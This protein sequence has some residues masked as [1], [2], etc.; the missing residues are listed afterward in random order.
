MKPTSRRAAF[1]IAVMAALLTLGSA[2]HAEPT[3]CARTINKEYARYARTLS[4]E[5]EKCKRSVFTRGE[6]ST[7]AACPDAAASDKIARA[8]QKLGAKIA[9]KCGG[10]NKICSD[11]D[12]G[13]DADDPL[14]AINWDI[15]TCMNF[16]AG[17]NGNC[18]NTIRHC[19]DVATCL[20]C[21]A[22]AAVEQEVDS[23]IYDRFDPTNFFLSSGNV[24][25]VQRR[26]SQTVAQEAVKFIQKKHKL[27]QKC[28]DKKLSGKS[29]FADGDPCPDTDPNIGHTGDNKTVEKIK[30]LE[31]RLVDKVCKKCGGG[32]DRNQDGICDEVGVPLTGQDVPLFLDDIVTLPFRCPPVTIPA[33]A[34]HPG[35]RDC[36]AIGSPPPNV[37]TIREYVD[38]VAC[39]TEF[40]ADCMSRAG[41]GDGN[42]GLGIAYPSADCNVCVADVEGQACPTT[43][44]VT[45]DGKNTDLD[46]GWSGLS[47]DF[48]I[49][50][51]G[52]LTLSVSNCDGATRPSC[53]ECDLSGPIANAGG[54]EFNNHRCQGDNS[55]TCNNDGDC[56][57]N[58]PCVFYFGVSLPLSS[59][60]VP[61]CITNE[62]QGAIT[63][64]ANIETADSAATINLISRVYLGVTDDHPCPNCVNGLCTGSGTPCT[65]N[66]ESALFGPLSFD[67]PP[68]GIIGTLPITLK[69]TT[70][71]QSIT[72]S[73]ANPTCTA[74]GWT[75]FKCFCDTCDVAGNVPCMTNADCVLAGGTTCG[76][77]RCLPP[78]TNLGMPCTAASQC[79]GGPCGTR[80]QP[81]AANQCADQICTPNP[82]D[83]DSSDEGICNAGPFDQ[84]CS[85]DRFLSCLA[86]SDCPVGQTCT[87]ATR[88]CY[89]DNG[90]IAGSVSVQGA[91]SQACGNISKPTLGTLFCIPP[92]ESGSVNAVA[93]SPGLGRLTLPTITVFNP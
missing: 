84:Q 2:A 38:C 82:G 93:G 42:P 69:P 68:S 75:T 29:G 8:A 34:V 88:E 55:I 60:G 40:K 44:E 18:D 22:D 56:G 67:C 74:G 26:C 92:T 16:E 41:V 31:A 23:L 65:V 76:G 90:M 4:N 9:S 19:G 64:T 11:T 49:P 43:V 48:D 7:L 51:N 81:T 47:H 10:G 66:G 85:I 27:L 61:V 32:G 37:T 50:T 5:L 17:S 62:V 80:G 54:L 25:R 73:A 57:A 1:P 12:Q 28:W 39:V 79:A 14:L 3:K 72:L 91:P 24:T 15:G 46:T 83:T 58:A 35:G 87:S 33:S 71:T 30:R 45:A 13:N 52:R 59:G 86:S 6:P 77:K 63:G 89:T 78:S 21:I 20:Q 70:G 36:G 53:G